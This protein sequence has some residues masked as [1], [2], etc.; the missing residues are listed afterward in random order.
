MQGTKRVTRKKCPYCFREITNDEIGF[1]LKTDGT[2]FLSP[3]L[4]EIMSARLDRMY[5]SF[6]SAMGIPEEQIDAHR[7][8]IDNTAISMLNQELSTSRHELAQRHYDEESQGYSFSVK[9]GALTIYSNTMLCPYCHNVLPQHFFHYEMLL[10]GLAGSVA[11][12]KTVYLSSLMMN[13]Y[14]VLQRENLSVR[15]AEGNP[16]DAYKMSM[17]RN[18]DR[19]WRY[20]ICPE[21]TGKAFRKPIFLE[22]TYKIS[23]RTCHML[24]A[25]YDVAGELIS[26]SAG[27]GRTGFV[28]H[29]DG[30]IC[31]VDPAQMHLEHILPSRQRPDEEKVLEKL[32]L[33]SRE[34]QIAVQRMSNENGCQVMSTESGGQPSQAGD[35]YIYERRAE[36]ILD[37]IRA[38]VGDTDL[39]NKYMAL[40]IAK[41]DL[42]EDL[43][44]IRAYNGSRLLFERTAVNYGFLNMDHHFL[45]QNILKQIFDQKVFRL[46]RNLDDYKE[47]GLFAVSALG[48]EVVETDADQESGPED[49]QYEK[50]EAPGS[51]PPDRVFKTVS[52]VS[53][54]RVEEPFMW[55]VMKA[56]QERGWL[57]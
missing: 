54:I 17:E 28:R 7:V 5:L 26:E 11:S 10:I 4:N 29:M 43:G 20:G 19:L 46:Q 21:A 16:Q 51:A 56:M 55:M 22:L 47:S 35:E 8:F 50:G 9:E 18:A 14:D 27:S 2:R 32:H 24:A 30:Y 25:I 34:E 39:K 40:T 41:S 48:C 45:R 6:W 33:L 15:S 1:L 44:E 57:D 3:A 13:S 42:L 23:D 49:R 37:S 31:L 12:G 52:R 38:G 53:P 36:M